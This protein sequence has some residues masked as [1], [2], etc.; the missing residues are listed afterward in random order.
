MQ[1]T[2]DHYRSL[3]KEGTLY[4]G[5]EECKKS[6]KPHTSICPC[7]IEIV[8]DTHLYTFGPGL[9]IYIQFLETIPN[10]HWCKT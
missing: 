8:H 5:R 10:V 7:D 4:P 1:P 9:V 3:Y 6:R 2:L